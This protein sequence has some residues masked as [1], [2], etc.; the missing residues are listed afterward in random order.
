[1]YLRAAVL[2]ALTAAAALPAGCKDHREQSQAS[3]AKGAQAA[4]PATAPTRPRLVVLVVVDQLPIW[5]FE[6]DRALL[7]G[8]IRRLLDDGVYYRHARYPYAGTFTAPGH[9]ALGTGAPPSVTGILANEWYRRD[10]GDVRS[11]VADPKAPLLAI[12]VPGL[13]PPD[14][15]DSAS[16]V[17]L[18]VEGVGDVLLRETGGRARAV[19]VGLKD[20]STV[21]VLGQHPSLA[22]FYDPSQPA[23]TTSAYYAKTPPPWLVDLARKHPVSAHEGDVWK[24]TDAE[25]LRKATGINDDAPGEGGAYGLGPTFPHRLATSTNPAKALR[26]TPA[27]NDIVFEAAHAALVGEKL[28][29]DDVP[30]ILAVLLSAHDYA[31]HDWGQESWERLDLFLRLDDSLGNFFD[32]L[33]R[34]IGKGNWAAVLTSDHGVAHLVEETR[35]GGGEARRIDVEEIEATGEKA[36][37]K[38]LGK[39]DWIAAVSASTIYVTDAFRARPEAQQEAALDAIVAAVGAMKDVALAERTDRLRGHCDTRHGVD[40]M[41]CRGLHATLSGE[42]FVAPQPGS[43]ITTAKYPT[44]TTHGSYNPDDTDVPILVYAPGQPARVVDTLVSTLQVAPTLA[45]MLGVSPPAAA[46]AL[47]LP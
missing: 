42:I 24:P 36:A 6:R 43:V 9:A 47:P 28:G 8:G 30:D 26:E 34:R 11:A 27:G 37:A 23:M 4:P 13:E 22:V 29:A 12:H 19:A 44:G 15:D 45:K 14:P 7:D 16:S 32:D 46:K 10:G 25:L 35:A 1:M 41:A 5:S 18:L 20:C 3:A 33:D 39:G 21:L 2:L 31:G 38:L 40:A 17:Q